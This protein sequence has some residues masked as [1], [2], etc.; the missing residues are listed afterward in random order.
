MVDSALSEVVFLLLFQ[1][2]CST[3]ITEED[4]TFA[5]L[6]HYRCHQQAHNVWTKHIRSSSL[7]IHGSPEDGGKRKRGRPPK[8][9][10]FDIPV[11]PKV[12]AVEGAEGPQ[13]EKQVGVVSG[14]LPVSG[15]RVLEANE[16]PDNKC[17]YFMKRHFHCTRPRCHHASDR[18]DVLQLHA[19]DFH[20]FINILPGFE[21]FDRDVNCR[22]P[23]CHNNRS[24]R[25][26]HCVR[27]KCDY[28]FVRYS[29][30]SQ[31]NRKH[32]L[33]EDQA[34]QAKTTAVILSD[35]KPIPSN[36]L[37]IPR[38]PKQ[39]V[40]NAL[41]VQQVSILPND[42]LAKT[43]VKAAGTYFPISSLHQQGGAVMVTLPQ[44]MIQVPGIAHMSSSPSSTVAAVSSTAGFSAAH[45]VAG[46]MSAGAVT[47]GVPLTVLLQQKASV[48]QMSWSGMQ[49]KMHH[50][51]AQNCGRPFCKL[52]KREHFHCFECNQAFSEPGRL[53]N[54]MA[55]HGIKIEENG[56]MVCSAVPVS[57]SNSS[58]YD[59]EKESDPVLDDVVEG[60]ED[61][62][63]EIN[64]SSSLT[65]N[66]NT[67]SDI[68][69]RGD[70]AIQDAKNSV[71]TSSAAAGGL[72][73][74]PLDD[75]SLMS[76]PHDLSSST[77]L[78]L[79]SSSNV[80]LVESGNESVGGG[81]LDL[82]NSGSRKSGRKRSVPN[83][84]DFVDSGS[85]VLKQRRVSSPRGG[86]DDFVPEGYIRFR[87][88]EN[89]KY[90]K[91]A[92]R[93]NLTHYHCDRVHCGY[94]FSD[95]SRM[96]QHSLRHERYDTIMG[97]EFRQYKAIVG[98]DFIGCDLSQVSTHFH[99]LRCP[100]VCLDT[101]KVLAHR[102]H[103]V[104]MANILALGFSKFTVKE[105]CGVETCNHSKKQSH[106]HCMEPVCAY[107]A[108]T[109]SQMAPHRAKHLVS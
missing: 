43:V 45:A 8:Y 102:K 24:N 91:C 67:F 3:V 65:L 88:S 76:E 25:H 23:H 59:T 107:V 83:N 9:P 52:K 29:T 92:Y 36:K 63:S 15:I 32:E 37:P 1:V 34:A 101:N 27:P 106:Y 55:K 16:C 64:A 80:S 85:I 51:T 5:R 22:R 20:N 46:E 90:P 81:A 100:F 12:E 86:K 50:S 99:C 60:E 35:N 2:D 109:P 105:D 53:R 44:G 33:L 49:M 68:I 94:S 61:N 30:M 48:P 6:E 42:L 41:P 13:G 75:D 11:V 77:S 7:G 104:K 87:F 70:K 89:C 4:K 96:V 21:F 73:L 79:M 66:P 93:E 39:T 31:H 82:N 17:V 71:A 28:S 95:R 74:P 69:A 84:D 72:Q 18:E 97:D 62:D 14:S 108:L 19:K 54:H 58:D 103:H 78:A 26:F 56:Q 38:N 57:S 98:C 10:R 40:P 47:G